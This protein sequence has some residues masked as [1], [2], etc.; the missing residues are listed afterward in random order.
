MPYKDVEKRR[1]YTRQDQARRRGIVRDM[2]RTA[3]DRPCEDCG[4]SY[5]YYVM[6][7]DHCRG[8]KEY[9]IAKVVARPTDKAIR[10]L[11]GELEKCDVVCANCHRLRH[12]GVTYVAAVA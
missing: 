10:E 11:P 4:A 5:P 12:G 6:E 9:A 1:E 2:V 7:F 8:E 3:K